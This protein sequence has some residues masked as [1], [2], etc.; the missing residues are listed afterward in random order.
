LTATGARKNQNS[1]GGAR[2]KVFVAATT[3]LAA[4]PGVYLGYGTAGIG[5]AIFYG[6]LIGIGGT[7]LGSLLARTA[8][9]LRYS[10]KVV[11]VTTGLV[12]V[13][14]LTWDVYF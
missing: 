7:L 1:L 3:V 4:L 9:L 10:W 8:L 12:L 13:T 5:G 6:V 14:I 2:L 11:V